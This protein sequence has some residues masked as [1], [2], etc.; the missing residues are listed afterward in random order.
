MRDAHGRVGRIDGLA[1]GAGG[2]EG[3]DAQVFGVNLNV[4]VFSFGKNSDGYRRGMPSPLLFC[5]RNALH[6]MYAAFVFKA[7]ID[8]IALNH[9]RSEERRVGKECRSRWTP[10]H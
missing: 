1:A 10:Y 6:A 4:D 7:R 9:G 5:F 3:V 8:A 2:A